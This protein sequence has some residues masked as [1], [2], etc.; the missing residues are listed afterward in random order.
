M[1]SER[2][3]R[4]RFGRVERREEETGHKPR[5]RGYY[6]IDAK[7]CQKVR[8]RAGRS[9]AGINSPTS[10]PG[11]IHQLGKRLPFPLQY[12][13]EQRRNK[14]ETSL[15]NQV[16]HHLLM[17]QTKISALPNHLQLSSRS[18]QRTHPSSS[19]QPNLHEQ[20]PLPP[21]IPFPQLKQAHKRPPHHPNTP[22][23]PQSNP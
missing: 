5:S 13:H 18:K 17:H 14:M 21:L 15:N 11:L 7:L 16:G 12:S 20:L 6:E 23:R 10:S 22:Q 4:V 19:A 1:K 9:I 2:M 3:K 8:S